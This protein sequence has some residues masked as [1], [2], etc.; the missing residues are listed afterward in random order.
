MTE[1]ITLNRIVSD[2]TQTNKLGL[3][4]QD[5]NDVQRKRAVTVLHSISLCGTI[6]YGYSRAVC[7][8]CGHTEIH[9]GTCQN[10][11]CPKCG[12]ARRQKWIEDQNRKLINAPAW[13]IIFT[14]PDHPLEP[15]F[16]E[17]PRF[18]YNALF[19]A[20]SQTVKKLCADPHY[21]GV[22]QPGFFSALHTWGSSLYLH[23]HIHMVLYGAGLN[24]K[25]ELVYVKGKRRYLFPAKKAAALFKREMMRILRK[26]YEYSF[27]PW[28]DNM[29]EAGDKEWNVEFRRP[30]KNPQTVINYLGRY[31]CRTAISNRRI[32]K[33]E[34]DRVSFEYKDYRQS[35]AK[36]IM[37]LS[38]VE[39]IRRFSWHIPPKGFQRIRFYGFLSSSQKDQLK[40][41]KEL[42]GEAR[43]EK[44]EKNR[45]EQ[46]EN[47]Y[48][49]C[50]KCHS[51][52]I[53]VPE[54]LRSKP[55]YRK[56]L[57]KLMAPT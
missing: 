15:M 50:P 43:I 39:F 6:A 38:A 26:E 23:P 51:E 42:A 16:R 13:H 25:G 45:D 27:S 22:T 44:P 19:K 30:M 21:F 49:F 2:L 24:E 57:G 29:K 4:L 46:K 1:K 5:L 48:R 34:N 17:N 53:M 37:T 41:M 32:K 18:M 12:E 40:K 35:G 14:V 33:Y 20:T 8:E 55:L 11:N 3:C 31:V 9:Y 7:P 56:A 52:Y 36:K 47:S 10:P 54:V 28:L